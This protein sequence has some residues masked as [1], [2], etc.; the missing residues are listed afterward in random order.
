EEAFK[1]VL[2]E[3]TPP[4]ILRTNLS[5]V[6]LIMK[7]SGIEDVLSFD[8]FDAPGTESIVKGLEELLA[9]GA[10]DPKTGSLTETGKLM[11]EC[12][13][14]PQLSRVLIESK[15][16]LCTDEVLTILSMLSAESIF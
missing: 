6:I 9:L 15:K 10:L 16:L 4:E 7:A 1:S 2:D 12:P 11:A 14:L 13:L 5:N 3:E 8:Y